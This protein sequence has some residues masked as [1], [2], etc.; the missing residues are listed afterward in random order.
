MQLDRLSFMA[1]SGMLIAHKNAE[2][3]GSFVSLSNQVRR[4]VTGYAKVQLVNS[5]P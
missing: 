3:S 4:V 5:E 2:P 1:D